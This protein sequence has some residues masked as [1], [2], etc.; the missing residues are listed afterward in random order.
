MV[1]R[2]LKPLRS[3]PVEYGEAAAT[4]LSCA[5]VVEIEDADSEGEIDVAADNW[6]DTGLPKLCEWIGLPYDRFVV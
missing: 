1:P 5:A 2:G 4:A 3:I 6:A